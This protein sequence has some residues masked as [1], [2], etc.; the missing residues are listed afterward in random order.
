VVDEPTTH[1]MHRRSAILVR[2]EIIR[3]SRKFENEP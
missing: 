2:R 1:I 3:N